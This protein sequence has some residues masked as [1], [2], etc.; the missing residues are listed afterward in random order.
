M[1]LY[2][3][4]QEGKNMTLLV[5]ETEPTGKAGTFPQ[6]RENDDTSVMVRVMVPARRAN[7]FWQMLKDESRSEF[8]PMGTHQS[9]DFPT[10]RL[11]VVEFTGKP[12][13]VN[14]DLDMFTKYHFKANV[15][16]DYKEAVNVPS[17][18]FV[19]TA[20]L[21]YTDPELDFNKKARTST[22]AFS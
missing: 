2:S 18:Q 20:E 17:I 11:M 4:V 7:R 16:S 22:T 12:K 10:H 3:K 14:N 8:V 13:E 1:L 19:Q 5:N 9:E 6:S 15:V 21:D